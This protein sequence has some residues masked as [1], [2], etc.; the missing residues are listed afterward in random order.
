MP[1]AA[2]R[3]ALMDAAQHYKVRDPW[4]ASFTYRYE[5]DENR[6]SRLGNAR[7]KDRAR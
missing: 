4:Q 6:Q 2:A 5:F 1:P 7:P 3:A